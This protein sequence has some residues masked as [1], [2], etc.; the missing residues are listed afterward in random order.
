L[1]T[2]IDALN[3]LQDSGKMEVRKKTKG[4]KDTTGSVEGGPGEREYP[5]AISE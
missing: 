1:G 2:R 3:D 4:E 5:A